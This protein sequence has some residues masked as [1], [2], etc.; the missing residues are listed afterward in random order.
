MTQRWP[1]RRLAMGAFLST[2]GSWA[3]GIAVSYYVFRETGS[4]VWVA[5]TLFFTLGV[6]GLFS[7]IAGKIADR[8]DRRRVLIVSDLASAA[9]W[10]ALVWVREPA[11][12]VALA[13]VGSLVGLPFHFAASAAVPNLAGEDDLGWA[14]G[15]LSAA[16]STGRLVGPALGGALFAFVGLGAVFAVNAASFV[17]SAALSASIRRVPFSREAPTDERVS[18]WEGFR[19]V[20][21]DDVR[22]RLLIAWAISYLAMNIA[23]VAD[24][25]LAAVFGVGAFGYGMLDTFFGGGATLGGLYARRVRT[26]SERRWIVIGLAGVGAGW[27]LIA[28]AP[29]FWVVLVASAAAAAIDTVGT[30]AGYGLIQRRTADAVRGRVFAA[31]SMA[32]M[33]ANMV[34]FLLVGPFVQAFG[35]RAVYAAGGVLSF[36]AAG[37]FAYRRDPA[38]DTSAVEA[39]D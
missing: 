25:P 11:F 13:F 21:A 7:P 24:P 2:V 4:A 19:V 30:A 32:G 28:G 22:K 17:A 14:N 23:F 9:C 33:I 29:W 38:V 34:G 26:G 27:L 10:L 36:V 18:A 37:V 16:S 12:V 35:P 1:I 31:Y 15:L 3:A 5:G 39:A 8:F 20:F 6:V